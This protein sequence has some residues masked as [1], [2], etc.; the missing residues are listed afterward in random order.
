M[1]VK[2]CLTIRELVYDQTCQNWQHMALP[3]APS[4]NVRNVQVKSSALNRLA[5]NKTLSL[6]Q[7]SSFLL[8]PVL[9]LHKFFD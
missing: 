7:Y 9:T 6:A 4:F 5:T 1:F 8:L 2:C 3:N